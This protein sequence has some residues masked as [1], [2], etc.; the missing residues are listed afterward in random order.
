MYNLTIMQVLLVAGVELGDINK[1][2]G[3]DLMD[4]GYL[5]FTDHRIP[6]TSMLMKYAQVRFSLP[7]WM[8]QVS[9]KWS[10]AGENEPHYFFN[11]KSAEKCMWLCHIY[12][13]GEE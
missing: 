13:F 5:K 7:L 10:N 6:R 3:Y 9:V 12:H 4:N 8:S 1:K 11:M 2:Y